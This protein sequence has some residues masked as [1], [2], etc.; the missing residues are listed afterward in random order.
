MKITPTPSMKQAD[1]MAFYFALSQM[2]LAF[3]L[4]MA[5]RGHIV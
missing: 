4:F 3:G 1:R 2:A 5:F